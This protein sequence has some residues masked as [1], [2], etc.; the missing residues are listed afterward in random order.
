MLSIVRRGLSTRSLVMMFL[1]PLP[2]TSSSPGFLEVPVASSVDGCG[3]PASQN[4]FSPR[5][6]RSKQ[7]PMGSQILICAIRRSGI[8]GLALFITTGISFGLLGLGRWWIGQRRVLLGGWSS[9]DRLWLKPQSRCS[10]NEAVSVILSNKLKWNRRYI[11]DKE[12]HLQ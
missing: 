2:D 8:S 9:R 5:S 7:L 11:M 6:L 3:A 12:M 1:Y 4:A 10:P